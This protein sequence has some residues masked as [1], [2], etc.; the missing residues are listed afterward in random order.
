MSPETHQELQRLL[1]G[2]CDDTLTEA[3]SARLEQLLEADADCRAL[4]LQ[5]LDMHAQL[6]VHPGHGTLFP[7]DT[8]SALA[9]APVCPSLPAPE[10]TSAT[11]RRQ[12][13]RHFLGYG[14]V[15]GVTLAASLLI[16]VLWWHPRGP[17]GKPAGEGPRA[18]EHVATLMQAVDCIWEGPSASL[19]IGSR[20]VPGRL[21]LQ[22]GAARI[23]FDSGTDLIVEGPAELT[24]ESSSAATLQ[25]GQVVFRT[26]APAA[27]I[28]LHT[29]SATLFD[30]GTEYAVRVGPEGE[31][32]QVFD[33]EVQRVPRTAGGEGEPEYVEAGEARRYPK[34]GSFRSEPTEFNPERFVR[35][36][37]NANPPAADLAAGL[38]AYEGFDYQDPH[39]LQNGQANG[40][41]GWAGSWG[42]GMARPL[43]KEA[44][45]PPTLN[46]KES[47]T[48]P[49]TVPSIG[50]CFEYTGFAVHQRRL[51]TPVRLDTDGV[52]YLSFLFRRQGPPQPGYS[53]SSVSVILRSDDEHQHRMDARKWLTVGVGAHN[54][55]YAQLGRSCSKACLPLLQGRDY[56]LVAKIVANSSTADQ[57]FLRVYRPGEPVDREETGSWTVVSRPF[58]SDQ[59]FDRLAI[60]VSGG[61]RQMIDEIRLGTTW[62]S[63]TA[64][65]AVPADDRNDKR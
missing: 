22:K 50:G 53:P 45:K 56:L 48:R 36:L 1:S 4:Y 39:A 35:R 49:G 23:R 51:A 58:E 64:W 11:T 17:E 44:P 65:A 63:V 32:I 8:E 33:G 31:E 24:L 19:R 26:E 30:F 57:I 12:R 38:L 29:P 16:Q 47:L 27:P 43:S 55:L 2:L 15:A 61:L 46:L 18:A 54:Q 10:P 41:F 7:A 3:E 62:S 34:A 40:G 59:V 37:P 5:Y 6:L 14:L 42:A 20:F 60:Q 52:Y 21:R 25:R 13:R 28:D 9:P